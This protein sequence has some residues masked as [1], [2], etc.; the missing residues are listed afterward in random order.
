ED[1]VRAALS[2]NE[3]AEQ[4]EL[5]VDVAES[6][7]VRARAGLL[8]TLTVGANVGVSAQPTRDGER[9]SSAATATLTQPLIAPSVWPAHS[10][11]KHL[12]E[13]ERAGAIEDR[14]RLA[15]E[16]ARTFLQALA[17]EQSLRAAESR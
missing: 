14:R 15:Y 16:V 9:W 2:R 8:P 3:R 1:A 11:A 13:A 12:L 10:Q 5:R 4:A 17:M 7:V 6:A